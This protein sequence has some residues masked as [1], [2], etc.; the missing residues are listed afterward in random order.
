MR[1]SI[2]LSRNL[3]V[4]RSS[5]FE[6]NAYR[7]SM[8]FIAFFS[9]LLSGVLSSPAKAQTPEEQIAVLRR[10]V[11]QLRQQLDALKEEIRRGQPRYATLNPAPNRLV[12]ITNHTETQTTAST[13]AEPSGEQELSTAEAVPLLQAQV[14]EHAQTKV[15]SNSKLPVKVFGT[16][17][18]NTFFNTG[19]P[20]SIELPDIIE[21]SPASPL[22]AGSFNATL[23]QSRLGA[24]VEGP[25]FGPFKTSGI[26]AFDFFGGSPELSEGEVVGVPRLLYAYA[27][28]EGE[29]T[30]LEVGQDEM[31]LAPKNPTSLAAFAIPDLYRSGNLYARLPQVRIEQKLGLGNRGELEMIGGILAPLGGYLG[32]EDYSK[33]R[34]SRQP[35][36]QARLAWRSSPRGAAQR[37]EWEFGVSGHY[38]RQHDDI[39]LDE[40][41]AA[42]IDFDMRVGRLGFGGEGYI[43]RT[44]GLFGGALGQ[45]GDATGGY[46]EGRI[47]ATRQLE[48]N[49][50]LGTDQA[51]RNYRGVVRPLRKNIGM[52]AN[53]IYRFTPELAASFEYRWL[54]TS[55]FQE[56]LRHNNHFNMSLAYSF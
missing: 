5:S 21:P 7:R 42:A 6:L 24:I 51:P 23:R 49:A 40:S 3:T 26:F 18:L 45:P 19:D 11:E 41:W 44:L 50:G 28:L 22:P 29:R 1:V 37:R 16:V 8:R 12:Q 55:P 43:G 48:F 20:G 35:A 2:R 4:F 13:T 14:A 33:A 34:R 53:T 47:K 54:S 36:F 39:G 52:F 32:Y 25:H 30:A 17:L 56:M 15:E 10:E 9:F 38:E 31:I 27:R 46:L